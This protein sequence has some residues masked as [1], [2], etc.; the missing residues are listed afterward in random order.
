MADFSITGAK[1]ASK[2]MVFELD[3]VNPPPQLI[4][5]INPE[6]LDIKFT[7]KVV[8]NRVRWTNQKDSSYIFQ[9]HHDELDILSASGQSAMFYTDKGLTSTERKKTLG[10]ENIQQLLAI[11]RNNGMIFNRKPGQRGTNV[12]ESVGRVLITYDEILYVGFFESFSL[13]EAAEKPFNLNFS[14]DF[15]VTK[16]FDSKQ[17]SR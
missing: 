3:I 4:I 6:S 16:H 11:Y 7:P 17:F 15:K 13:N 5:L 8:E 10:W 2:Q 9:V 14:F 1:P 12:L